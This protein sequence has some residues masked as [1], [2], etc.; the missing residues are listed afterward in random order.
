[1]RVVVAIIQ[2][3][4]LSTVRDALR[5]LNLG[6]I[7]VCDAMGYGRQRGQ[8]ALFRGNE[9]KVDLLRKV[10]VEVLVH[11][12]EL[13]A[14]IDTISRNALTGSVGQ[15]GDGKIFVLP[16]AQVIDLADKNIAF[17]PVE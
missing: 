15:I 4:K 10:V 6:E 14:V 12:D 17:E 8:S 13:E 5:E 11:E 7:T 9:Y 3:T 2:P 1:M 16:V